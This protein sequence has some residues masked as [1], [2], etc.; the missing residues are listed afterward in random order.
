MSAQIFIMDDESEYGELIMEVAQMQSLIAVANQDPLKFEEK[1]AEQPNVD[2]LFL[3]LN[4]PNRDG[5]EILRSLA[6]MDFKGRIVLMSGFD[7]SVLSTAYEL[8]EVYGLLLLSPL[9]KPFSIHD[10]IGIFS[11][12]LIGVAPS[13]SLN[14]GLNPGPE[15]MSIEAIVLALEEGRV[16][17]H[18]QPQI[19]LSDYSV[20][21]YESLVRLVDE[22]GKLC[23]PGQF[24]EV[25]EQHAKTELLLE[26]VCEQVCIDYQSHLQLLGDFTVSINVSALD[27]DDLEFPEK[28]ARKIQCSNLRPSNVVIEITESRAIQQITA[29]LDIL[30]RLRLK[31]FHLSIDDFGTGSAVLSNIKKMPFTELKIDKSFVDKVL[32]DE[33]TLSLTQSLID[34]GHNLKMTLVAEGIE[35]IE[36]ARFLQKMG[37]DIAQ[38]YYFARPMPAD[39]VSNWLNQRDLDSLV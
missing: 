24:I 5:I 14:D 3:D 38:G 2:L 19:S 17:M 22:G 25:I 20:V 21:G 15:V 33:R 9:S 10:V 27:L 28:F 12:H 11:K 32:S 1:L 6:S 26:K 35:D 30:A 18:Y 29:G 34:M 13:N 39:E 16:C 31:G 4:M 7:E 8:A 36:T 37:C 23:Y